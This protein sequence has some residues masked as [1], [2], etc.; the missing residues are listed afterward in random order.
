M[1]L[2]HPN[3]ILETVYIESSFKRNRL[4]FLISEIRQASNA[5]GEES[6]IIILRLA[7]KMY[8]PI[9]GKK[10]IENKQY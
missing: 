10:H 6:Y 5:G 7:Q 4:Y 1:E 9:I 8:S 3:V 2:G